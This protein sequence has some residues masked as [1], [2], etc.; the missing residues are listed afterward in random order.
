MVL[1]ILNGLPIAEPYALDDLAQALGA[2][3]PTPAALG[4]FGELEDHGERGLA[5]QKTMASAVWRDRQPLVLSVRS[6]TV[7]NVLSI[8]FDVRT[9]FQCSAGKS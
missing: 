4:R 6:R 2:V 5:R 1:G 7:A 9:C 8:G 3:E